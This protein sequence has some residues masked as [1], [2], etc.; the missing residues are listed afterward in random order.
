MSIFTNHYVIDYNKKQIR[1]C[2]FIQ[3][4]LIFVIDS[5]DATDSINSIDVIDFSDFLFNMITFLK[6][7]NLV[8]KLS[9][10]LHMKNN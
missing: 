8:I 3:E 4:P 1:R 2:F 6:M 5:T 7:K 10:Y 9:I